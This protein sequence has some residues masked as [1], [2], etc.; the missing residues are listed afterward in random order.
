MSLFSLW[1]TGFCKVPTFKICHLG[2]ISSMERPNALIESLPRWFLYGLPWSIPIGYHMGNQ[3]T[4]NSFLC[5]IYIL[6]FS[7][8]KL[9]PVYYYY[10][11]CYESDH[12]PCFLIFNWELPVEKFGDQCTKN[13]SLNILI[14]C[15][16]FC[17]LD[18]S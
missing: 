5:K 9:S 14:K 1:M 16:V 6:V 18:N 7:Q 4:Y 13:C 15:H 3:Y 10:H 17:C 2:E 8:N 12:V 11:L